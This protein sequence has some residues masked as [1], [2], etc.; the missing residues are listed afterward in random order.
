MASAPRAD[1]IVVNNEDLPASVKPIFRH[2]LRHNAIEYKGPGETINKR[3]IW[4]T[5]GYGSLLIGTTKEDQ[6]QEDQLTLTMFAS[7][8]SQNLRAKLLENGTL[9]ATEEKGIYRVTGLTALPFYIVIT[10]ELEGD[11]YA[12]YRAL[13][14]H[15]K[16]SDV[17]MILS[18]FK[19]AE[20]GESRDRYHRIL[21]LIEL[22]NPGIVAKMLEGDAKMESVFM[23]ILEPQIQVKIDAAVSAAKNQAATDAYRTMAERMI[24]D[25]MPGDK[26]SLFTSLGRSDIDGIASRLHRT[27]SWETARA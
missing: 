20:T 25:G 17:K 13:T 4:K 15:A 12:A 24:K 5:A 19:T 3:M 22:K 11:G 23:K 26:I 2:F 18:A 7:K 21:Q 14:D 16:S 9:H 10:D 8:I 27:V 6:Y 1:F